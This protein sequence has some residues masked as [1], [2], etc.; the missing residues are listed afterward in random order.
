MTDFTSE[1][2]DTVIEYARFFRRSVYTKGLDAKLIGSSPDAAQ[3]H[4]YLQ[5]FQHTVDIYAQVKNVSLEEALQQAFEEFDKLEDRSY[6]QQIKEDLES[7]LENAR[8][9]HQELEESKE[10]YPNTYIA[11][12]FNEVMAEKMGIPKEALYP[13]TRKQAV[14]LTGPNID[15]RTLL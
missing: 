14:A 2:L 8:K 15:Q 1:Q 3:Q 9:E 11:E 7:A 5:V 13:S 12:K 10:K 6:H 4:P